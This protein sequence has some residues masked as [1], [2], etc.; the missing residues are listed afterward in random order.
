[1]FAGAYWAARAESRSEAAGR[2]AVF[3]RGL[4]ETSAG[5]HAWYRKGRTEVDASRHPIGVDV[6]SIA[7]EL[8]VSRR[9]IGREPIPELGFSFSAWNGVDVSLHAVLGAYARVGLN[10]VVVDAEVAPETVGSDESVWRRVIQGLVDAFEPEHAA[11]VN[12]ERWP[13]D[14]S[15]PW[16]RG[17]LRYVRPLPIEEYAAWR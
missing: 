11:V 17:W 15:R 10:S 2:L 14:G 9:D 1:M 4:A 12:G 16:E 7:R 8:K 3:L 5:L 6:D 13:P